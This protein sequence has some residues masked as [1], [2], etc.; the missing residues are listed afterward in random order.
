[1]P[2]RLTLGPIDSPGGDAGDADA[3][4]ITAAVQ[5]VGPL[6]GGAYIVEGDVAFWGAVGTAAAIGVPGDPVVLAADLIQKGVNCP[7]DT[8][9]YFETDGESD[10]Y[11][12]WVRQ[13]GVDGAS[14]R[15]QRADRGW[16]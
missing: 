2:R 12:A 3:Q 8:E 11:F 6:L 16:V 14:L 10:V 7:A 15:L 13:G 9:I 4:T 5:I 1:M